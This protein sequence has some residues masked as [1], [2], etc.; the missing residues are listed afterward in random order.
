M[1]ISNYTYINPNYSYNRYG[2]SSGTNQSNNTF[3]RP[4]IEIILHT[5]ITYNEEYEAEEQQN[6]ITENE[7]EDMYNDYSDSDISVETDDEEEYS[8]EE[9]DDS[10]EEESYEDIINE[11]S[12]CVGYDIRPG[13]A[14]ENIIDDLKDE[15]WENEDILR[16]LDGFYELQEN[17]LY[18]RERNHNYEG[19]HP[20]EQ[21]EKIEVLI[22]EY[23]RIVYLTS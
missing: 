15:N 10:E 1:T 7:I 21:M 22:N 9:E 11:A 4:S 13:K 14:L 6:I 17:T 23:E 3:R 20:L 8:D 19:C 12:D 2:F 5:N 16:F 18:N